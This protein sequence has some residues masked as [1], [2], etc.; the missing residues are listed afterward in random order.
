VDGERRVALILVT[1]PRW[2]DDRI[3]AVARAA[4]ASV[5]GFSVQL[6]DRSGR[7][8][9]ELMPLAS[10]LREITTRANGLLVV[11]RRL[12]LARRALA[13][14]FHAP[15]ADL[16]PARDFSWRSAPVHDD[17]ELLAAREHGATAVFVSPIFSTSGKT[18]RGTAALRTARAAAPNLEIVALGGIDSN[19]AKAC[20]EAGANAVAVMRALLDAESPGEVAKCLV[21]SRA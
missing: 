17:E 7:T 20:F 15:A 18:P 1:D 19:G 21:P 9:E 10:S 8:D 14:G 13:D 6:R 2:D 12:A 3:V 11:N 4:A 16:D 5:P